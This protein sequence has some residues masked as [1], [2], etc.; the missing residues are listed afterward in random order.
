MLCPSIFKWIPAPLAV[1]ALCM[2]LIL[3][4][5]HYWTAGQRVDPSSN[6]TFVWRTSNTYTTVSGMTYT[7]W[8]PGQPDYYNHREPCM[9]VWSDDQSYRWNDVPCS[10]AFCYVCELDIRQ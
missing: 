9:C 10:Y 6:S 7:N 1:N 2:S 4:A 5:V 3:C 8:Y